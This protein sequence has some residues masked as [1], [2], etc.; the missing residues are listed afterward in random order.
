MPAQQ[1]LQIVLVACFTDCVVWR[2]EDWRSAFGDVRNVALICMSVSA[3]ARRS[4]ETSSYDL[5]PHLV[6]CA[7]P[8]L[9]MSKTLIAR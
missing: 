4:A 7:S 8:G 1:L 5:P 2:C 6:E 3:Q 9:D